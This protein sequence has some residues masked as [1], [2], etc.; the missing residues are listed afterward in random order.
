MSSHQGTESSTQTDTL[1]EARLEG[2]LLELLDHPGI[3]KLHDIREDEDYLYLIM[4]LGGRGDLKDLLSNKTTKG[5]WRPETKIM[6]AQILDTIGY[7]HGLG[8]VHCDIKVH[9]CALSLKT[10]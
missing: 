2:L 8:I 1:K 9:T 7:L 6:L 5:Q 3:I 4:Q 10:L